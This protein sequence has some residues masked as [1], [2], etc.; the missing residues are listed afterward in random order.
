MKRYRIFTIIGLLFL[1]AAIFIAVY[2]M[3]N[4]RLAEEAADD[5]LSQLEP[6]IE[7]SGDAVD[8]SSYIPDY[9]LNPDMDMPVVEIDGNMY[10]GILKIPALDLELPVMSEWSYPGLKTAPCRYAG[11]AY[12]NNLV[13]AAH[14][15][16]AHF[17]RIK[18]LSAGD[19]VIFSDAAGN[20]FKYRVGGTETLSPY[21]VPEM[22]DG[23]WDLTLFTCTIGG[24][25]RVTVRCE[26]E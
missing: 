3:W 21:A 23:E 11:S 7:K 13:I 20:V 17:G 25:Q 9:V 4:G 26:L 12:L 15:Y 22:T 2:N 10:I 24:R 5:A 8:N 14:N 1:A 6:I 18:N 16:S 19:E